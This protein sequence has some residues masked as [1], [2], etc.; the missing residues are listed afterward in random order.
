MSHRLSVAL[1]A[2]ALLV[3]ACDASPAPTTVAVGGEVRLLGSF[4]YSMPDRFG[5]DENDDGRP[6]VPNSVGY[7]LNGD[8]A[9]CDADCAE[10]VFS[11]VLDAAGVSVIDDRN[12][13]VAIDSFSWTIHRTGNPMAE[14]D[15]SPAV[16]ALPEGE[17]DVTL[18][19]SA[20][21]Q[22]LTLED[23]IVVDDFLVVA[24][25]DSYA[26]GEGNPETPG[27]PPRWADDGSSDGEQA[28]DHDAAHRSSLA[29]A[30]Q[31]ALELESADPRTS[32]TFVFL[33]ASGA[34]L[35]DGVLAAGDP[36]TTGDGE[37]RELDPQLDQLATLLGCDDAGCRR[38]VDALVVSAGGNDIGFSFTVGSLIALDPVLV[39]DP[40]YSNLLDNLVADVAGEIEALPEGFAELADRIDELSVEAVYLLAYPDS[41]TVARG[42]RRLICDEI[43]GDL[44]P[45]LEVDGAELDVVRERLLGP[46]NATLDD[47]AETHGWIYVTGHLEEFGDHGYCGDDP[48]P[49]SDSYSGTAFPEPV[50]P[51]PVAGA[52]WFRQAAE[53]ASI[54]GGGGGIL[55]PER[56]AT[57]GTFHP[58]EYG[59]RSY[60]DALLAVFDR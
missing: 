3:T 39:V 29:G 36:V 18:E 14:A 44:F 25:G 43:G 40:I 4:D 46:L 30:A 59:H 51:S 5:L 8:T 50:S 41:S 16:V 54:Q 34:S 55:R 53:S 9:P 35:A 58:N 56:L 28:R 11:V 1:L 15:S 19:V 21:G 31:A 7:V 13:E 27:D 45:G 10:S 48:Y 17:F 32:V 6:D 12:R 57:N 23:M 47:I 24:I 2:A 22:S 52:R 38:S 26:S 20:G 42:G 60:R 37:R 49:Q 33:A